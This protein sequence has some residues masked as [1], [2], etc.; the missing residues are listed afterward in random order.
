ML[1][2]LP[3]P[4]VRRCFRFCFCLCSDF[5]R[6]QVTERVFREMTPEQRRAQ[7]EAD[8]A[9][10]RSLAEA[11]DAPAP[12]VAPGGGNFTIRAGQRAAI[13][14]H[15]PSTRNHIGETFFANYVSSHEVMFE[16]ANAP[17]TILLFFRQKS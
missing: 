4:A 1:A 9:F 15:H 17:G 13:R 8:A 11:E 5:K 2:P 6:T 10:A 12:A 16:L 7:E 14:L 3:W